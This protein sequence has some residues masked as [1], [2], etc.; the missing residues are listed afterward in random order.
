MYSLGVSKAILEAAGSTVEEECKELGKET[1]TLTA[2]TCIR[3]FLLDEHE[4]E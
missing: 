2:D 1:I 4:H 3:M